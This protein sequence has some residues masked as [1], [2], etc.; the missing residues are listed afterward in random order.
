MR[1]LRHLKLV[2]DNLKCLKFGLIVTDCCVTS[3]PATTP[4]SNTTTT[5]EIVY[6]LSANSGCIMSI[7]RVDCSLLLI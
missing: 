5:G 7:M 1:Q 3:V 6:C 2:V 4:C